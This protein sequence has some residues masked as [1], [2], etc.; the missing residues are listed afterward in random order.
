MERQKHTD[1]NIT[2]AAQSRLLK[3]VRERSF[4]NNPPE[5][6]HHAI[7]NGLERPRFG[8]YLR[9]YICRKLTRIQDYATM[10]TEEYLQYIIQSFA[11][12]G[13]P[14]SF[15]PGTTTLRATAKNWLSKNTISR[16]N[17]F[18]LGL[19]LGMKPDEVNELLIK[20][21]YE[22]E[23]N[24]KDPFEVICW[25]CYQYCREEHGHYLL[26]QNLWEKYL[27]ISVNPLS[28]ASRVTDGTGI[29]RSKMEDIRTERELLDFL[30]PLKFDKNISRFSL[31]ARRNFQT[32]Y[33]N[34]CKLI[35]VVDP[36]IQNSSEVTALLVQK[37]LYPGIY[38]IK[39]GYLLSD[40]GSEYHAYFNE[41]RLNEQR[42]RSLLKSDTK[43]SESDTP[44]TTAV[45]RFDLITLIFLELCLLYENPVMTKSLGKQEVNKKRYDVFIEKTNQI[46]TTCFMNTLMAQNPYEA[47]L[48]KCIQTD[49]P[50]EVYNDVMD[51]LYPEEQRKKLVENEQ[52][53]QNTDT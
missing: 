47:F 31:T 8:D 38:D 20:G 10:D 29:L 39:T 46:L 17:V 40:K 41:K 33:T 23:I 28:R 30:T 25:Y 24:P 5:S 45:T 44:Q 19:G 18:L 7:L 15:D 27:A 52:K 51:S 50:R 1:P 37:Y 35:A 11:K 2:K 13:T 32:L 14:A 26:Y 16:K 53:D 9:R 34:V 48:M 6:I 42:I 4:Q 49:D 22:Q 12:S 43:K 21:I 36:E 3:D